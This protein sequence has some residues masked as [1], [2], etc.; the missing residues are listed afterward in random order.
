MYLH[1][2]DELG[3]MAAEAQAL[4][5]FNPLKAIGRALGGAG[6]AIVSAVAPG[7]ATALDTAAR[8][9]SGTT[10]VVPVAP[11][12]PP[13]PAP[14]SAPVP[15]DRRPRA[16]RM[17]QPQP[18]NV[19]TGDL[20]AMLAKM[21]QPQ[22]T[23]MQPAAPNISVTTPGGGIMPMQMQMPAPSAMPAWLIPAGIAGLAAVF[24]LSRSQGGSR[25]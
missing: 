5:G 24:L 6:R 8:A 9:P 2:R 14:G 21:A 4:A 15:A 19:P 22:G 11:A 23:M 13:A 12:Q 3:E 10:T 7:V 17:G 25:R 18:S 1:Q 16:Q 20:F